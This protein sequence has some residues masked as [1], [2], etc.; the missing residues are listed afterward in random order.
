MRAPSWMVGL[1]ALAPLAAACRRNTAI[2]ETVAQVDPLRAG[3]TVTG[4]P[5]GAVSGLTRLVP[6]AAVGTDAQG[7][8][9]VRLDHGEVLLL[10]HDARVTVLDGRRVRLEAGRVWMTGAAGAEPGTL[11]VGEA[12]LRLQD[13]RASVVR[14]AQG[15]TVDV[16]RGEVAYNLGPHRGAVRAGERGTLRPDRA[17]VAPRPLFDD[18][19]GGLADDLAPDSAPAGRA[20]GLGAVSARRPDESGAPR[21]PMV[22]QRLDARVTV[23]GDLAVTELEQSFFNPA[24]DTVE[25]LYTLTVPRG[26]VL[27]RFAVDRRG[28][29]VD[30]VV[31]E[32][33]AAAAAYQAQVYRG[34]PFDPALL[35]WDAPGTYHARLFPLQPASTRRIVVTYTQWLPTGPDGLRSYRLP[36]AGLGTRIGELRAHIDLSQSRATE[37]RASA[38]AVRDE[39][40]V[41]FASSDVVPQSDLVVELRAAPLAEATLVRA[42]SP[43]DATGRARTGASLD[44]AGYVRVAVQAPFPEARTARDEGVDLVL[45]VD[46]SAAT[47]PASVQLQQ[48]TAEALV[49]ALSPRDRLLVLAGDVG[50]RPA[51]QREA[52]LQPATV[53]YQRAALDGLSRDRRGGAT[54]LGAMI[55]AAQGA[56]DPQRNGAIVY[57][58]DGVATVGE[59]E[60]PALRARLARMTPRPRL[61]AVAVG[62]APRLDVLSGITQPAGYAV[63]VVQR[64]EVARA[65]QELVAHAARPLVRDFRVDLG[66]TVERVYPTAGVDLPAGE[67][68]VVLGRITG[69]SPRTAT[70]RASWQGREVVRTVPVSARLVED[71]N[72]LRYRWATAR[73]DHLLAEGEPR[74]VVV[75][76]GTRY[77]LI[78]PYT[79]LFVP[80]ED[81]FPAYGQRMPTAPAE[82]FSVFDL[83]PLVGC[84]RRS[85]EGLAGESAPAPAAAPS[86]PPTSTITASQEAPSGGQAAQHNRA[87]SPPAEPS[88]DPA[89]AEPAPES[90][91]AAEEMPPPPPVVDQTVQAAPAPVAV[92][93]PMPMPAAQ[94]MAPQAAAPMGH[95]AFGGGG[96]VTGSEEGRMG[97]RAAPR[98]A[99]YTV[100]TPTTGALAQG[101]RDGMLNGLDVDEGGSGARATTEANERTVQREVDDRLQAN[102]RR[103]GPRGNSPDAS[104]PG[105]RVLLRCSDA[106]AVS[107][108]ERIPLWRE[109]VAARPH[110]AGAVAIWR[111]ARARCELPAWADRVALLRVVTAQLREVDQQLALYR[112]LPDTAARQW[113]RDLVLRNLARSGELARAADFDL[114][115]LDN[116]TLTAALAQATTPAARLNVLRQLVRR[117]GDDLDL[118]LLLLDAAVVAGDAAEVRRTATRLRGD[119]RTDA[120]VRTAAGEALLAVGDEAEARRTFSEI[121]EFAPDDPFARR[122]LGDIALAHGWAEE[123]YRQYQTLAAQLADAPEILLRLAAAA[124]G[125]GRLDEALRLAERVVTQAEPGAQG[126]ITEAAAAWIALEL[127]LAGAEPSVA[128]DTLSA[129]RARWRRSPAARSAGALR[130]ALRWS[131]P[132]DDAE[133]WLTLPDE[134]ARRADLVANAFPLEAVT[135]LEAPQRFA[136]E[137]RRGGGAR[138]RGEAELV[139]LWD[140][141]R[142]TERVARHRLR[143]DPDHNVFRFDAAGT[144]LS[145]RAETAATEVAR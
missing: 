76:L 109:R 31:Q 95:G 127:A 97:G 82:P 120:R 65:A 57:L 113:V 100:T 114:G 131:H 58:G 145:P 21:W 30:G 118:A 115:R 80:G 41:T 121:V 106:A 56:L 23:L 22:L 135:L 45:V 94:P 110:P 105:A 32:R 29:L 138:P 43:D 99:R 17:A 52:R 87:P 10:D 98:R 39:H 111:D 134:P 73:L 63:R 93:A 54:D 51:G 12:A 47:D 136:V 68:L 89:A 123:A 59:A 25:G 38:G 125:G 103:L 53:E 77:G 124:R 75:E 37:V 86:S 2:T 9:L 112:T 16:V 128:R 140:E 88:A 108:A 67:P 133:L 49:R 6:G 44:R 5:A 46:R 72:D 126:T 85:L 69:P 20:L 4:G 142:P 130:I 26:A 50:T 101:H 48:A 96:A 144:T 143:F 79:S 24:S 7:R 81:Q 104:E 139:V 129:L 11:D 71:R 74:M 60:L 27:Q 91:S 78:T 122:R 1:V 70:V 116:A 28:R 61:Y 42:Q 64:A 34:S 62:E 90:A 117:F 3:V 137:V 15:V 8:A 18:W 92:A 132:D 84:S 35:E 13:A 33:A 55:D 141:G 36:L 107:L 119:A 102:A 40:F 66:P 83:I 19:T 14:D